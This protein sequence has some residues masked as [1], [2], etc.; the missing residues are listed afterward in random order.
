M[1][2]CI[3]IVL[4]GLFSN[5]WANSQ[6]SEISDDK[7]L[8]TLAH[9]IFEQ[10]LVRQ[11][12]ESTIQAAL[13]KFKLLL[14]ADPKN[15]LFLA[16][17]GSIYTLMSQFAWLPW[18]K[19]R[20]TKEG[21]NKIKEALQNLKSIHDS[22]QLNVGEVQVPISIETRV[23]A[24]DTFLRVSD[25]YSM[26]VFEAVKAVLYDLYWSPAFK[27]VPPSIHAHFHIQAAT[28]AHQENKPCE[29]EKL[30]LQ[31][32]LDIAFAADKKLKKWPKGVRE[33]LE[34]SAKTAKQQLEKLKRKCKSK[35]ITTKSISTEP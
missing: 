31:K 25:P 6:N 13:H 24:I 4:I 17:Q 9:K 5:T 35:S 26:N 8:L 15:P 32:S 30:H 29:E 12:D 18:S 20:Y 22:E 33:K 7:M 1:K 28:L 34:E 3:L 21:L 11:N 2:T 27:T 23:V 16:Y 14:S 19:N 10:S